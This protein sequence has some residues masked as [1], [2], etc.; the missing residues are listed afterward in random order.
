MIFSSDGMNPDADRVQFGFE[1]V[2]GRRVE[3]SFDGGCLLRDR[4][5]RAIGLID[6]FGASQA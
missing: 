1:L 3:M 2:E 6:R 4:I 5:S